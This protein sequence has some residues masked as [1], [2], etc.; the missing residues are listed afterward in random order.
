MILS[1]L[2]EIGS[3][4]LE[5]P[6]NRA[7]FS[8]DAV[9]GNPLRAFFIHLAA[10]RNSHSALRQGDVL[11]ECDGHGRVTVERKTPTHTCRAYINMGDTLVLD[12]CNTPI[13][14]ERGRLENGR[15][16][17]DNSGFMLEEFI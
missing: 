14:L 15:L 5:D 7:F 12:A 13:L 10:V 9:A 4:G 3:E 6:F 2:H 8:W 1:K 16:I 17:L 11:V